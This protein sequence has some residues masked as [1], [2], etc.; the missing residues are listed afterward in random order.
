M[1]PRLL[2][3]LNKPVVCTYP[4]IVYVAPITYSEQFP[5]VCTAVL[6]I[7]NGAQ[8]LY[9]S[10][11]IRDVA[12]TVTHLE[13]VPVGEGNMEDEGSDGGEYGGCSSVMLTC[14]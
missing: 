8:C 10:L 11:Y 1:E 6:L 7:F 5:D 2:T 4:G 14:F 12:L 13:L 3:A 9:I